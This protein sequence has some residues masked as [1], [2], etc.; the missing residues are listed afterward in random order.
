MW[1]VGLDAVFELWF[2]GGEG[3]KKSSGTRLGALR[4][5]GRQQGNRETKGVQTNFMCSASARSSG[6]G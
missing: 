1:S 6:S 2:G 4:N 3:R 5:L